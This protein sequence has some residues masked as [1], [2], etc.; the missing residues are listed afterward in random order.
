[1]CGP[2]HPSRLPGL[3]SG[4]QEPAQAVR[5]FDYGVGPGRAEQIDEEWRFN[6]AEK[7][8]NGDPDLFQ[9][10]TDRQYRFPTRLPDGKYRPTR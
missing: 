3:Y 2:E 10:L 5:V 8:K 4:V 7:L 1:M 6:T 9:L